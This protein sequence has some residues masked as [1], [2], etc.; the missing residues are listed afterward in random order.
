MYEPS[1][2]LG[3]KQTRDSNGI[4]GETRTRLEEEEEEEEETGV[5]VMHAHLLR[6]NNYRMM[7]A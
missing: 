4:R 3:Q 7:D 1:G 5:E 2:C 6:Q